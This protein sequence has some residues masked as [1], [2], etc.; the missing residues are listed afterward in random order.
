MLGHKRGRLSITISKNG[1]YR[2]H[3]VYNKIVSNKS[4]KYTSLKLNLPTKIFNPKKFIGKAIFLM[5][6]SCPIHLIHNH[7]KKGFARDEWGC[8][9]LIF[10]PI[11]LLE[12]RNKKT[13]DLKKNNYLKKPK[14]RFDTKKLF[15]N[16]K[17][18][19]GKIYNNVYLYMP[20]AHNLDNISL[21]NKEV[22]FVNCK[23]FDNIKYENSFIYGLS[24]ILFLPI[25]N[26]NKS[27]K[28]NKK[29]IIKVK[30]SYQRTV[31]FLRKKNLI[32]HD[33][34]RILD[35]ASNT[36]WSHVAKSFQEQYISRKELIDIIKINTAEETRDKFFLS[37]DTL[38]TKYRISPYSLRTDKI[39]EILNENSYGFIQC[40]KL[41]YIDLNSDY[42]DIKKYKKM[43]QRYKNRK[44]RVF[45]KTLY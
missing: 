11:S 13:F 31:D 25:E 39:K 19:K 6:I 33:T 9:F 41:L 40:F 2:D 34:V 17:S 10:L 29:K 28:Y 42:K 24:Y 7:N 16:K 8:G 20:K 32:M 22:T 38:Q 44:D 37:L 5:E 27:V 43:I 21:K 3:I 18:S 45:F 14:N 12:K 15:I 26:M 35:I 1:F 30:Y 36:F 23:K 4:N